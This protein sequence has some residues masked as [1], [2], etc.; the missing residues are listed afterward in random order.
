MGLEDMEGKGIGM[1]IPA[2]LLRSIWL[3]RFV[4]LDDVMNIV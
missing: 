1:G 4:Y 2:A 3:D